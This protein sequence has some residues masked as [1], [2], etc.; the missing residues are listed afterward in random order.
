MNAVGTY[1]MFWHIYPLFLLFSENLSMTHKIYLFASCKM[2]LINIFFK[3]SS[4]ANLS[5][6]LLIE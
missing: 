6:M 1:P 3:L 5:Q 4:F 2:T